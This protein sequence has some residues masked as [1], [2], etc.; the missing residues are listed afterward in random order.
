MFCEATAMRK[1]S[2]RLPG[3][4]RGASTYVVSGLSPRNPSD[5]P[6]LATSLVLYQVGIAHSGVRRDSG[7]VPAG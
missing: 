6:Q 5:T 1:R 3:N 7:G 2:V 4:N